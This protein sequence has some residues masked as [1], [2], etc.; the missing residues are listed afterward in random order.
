MDP[1]LSHNLASL[2]GFVP[3]LILVGTMLVVILV[4]LVVGKPKPGLVTALGLIGVVLAGLTV[5]T[6]LPHGQVLLFSGML[7]NDRFAA[8]FKVIAA[9]A[10]I[11]TIVISYRA[12]DVRREDFAEYVEMALALCLGMFVMASAVNLLSMFLAFEMVSMTSYILTGHLKEN[13]KSSEAALKYVIYSGASSATMIYGMSLLYGVAG[14]LGAQEIAQR[15]VSGESSL[16]MGVAVL[17]V[18]AG[19][20]YKI[21]SVPFHFW[22]PDAYEG[23]PTPVAAFLSVGPKAA[24]MALLSRF[25]YEAMAIPGAEFQTWHPV[26]AADWQII[27]AIISAATMTLGNLAAI[28]QNNIKRLLAY[29]SIAH[30]GY[31]L[32][33]VAMI[34]AMG[35]RAMLFYLAVYLFMNLGAFF[36]IIALAGKMK[37]DELE[38]YSGLG[39]RA[40]F[41]AVAMAIF[42]LALAGIPPTA[43]FIGKFYLFWAVIEQNNLIWLAVVAALNTVVALFYY[44]RILRH[45]YLVPAPQGS[46]DLAVSP[47]STA[48][49]LVLLVPTLLFGIYWWPLWRWVSA[50]G[51][52]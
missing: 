11:F 32:M 18:L 44:A 8:F 51:M 50:A 14:S 25:L 4:D 20:G 6:N 28:W 23:A 9:A 34:S 3:E 46:R 40:P 17:F 31:I 2:S 1:I 37:S 22:C 36:V 10:T 5:V 13:L 49:L 15:L 19:L 52:P 45:M 24:G 33:G 43:G 27:I 30:A 35:M 39:S 47:L 12:I 29:S 21:A 42:L 26:G 38:A 48:I 7:A 16:A 41:V